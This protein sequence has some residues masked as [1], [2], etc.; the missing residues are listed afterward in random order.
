[1]NHR[2]HEPWSANEENDLARRFLVGASPSD[3]DTAIGRS[4][5]AVRGRLAKLGLIP[6]LKTEEI[7][8]LSSGRCASIDIQPGSNTNHVSLDT[9]KPVTIDS[10][11]SAFQT[12]SIDVQQA[13]RRFHFVYDWPCPR[14]AWTTGG[15]WGKVTQCIRIVGVPSREPDRCCP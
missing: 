6:P 10:I 5:L 1:M 11:Q 8:A 9:E 14:L 2:S 3:T 7:A 12:P 15:G 4:E 13:F